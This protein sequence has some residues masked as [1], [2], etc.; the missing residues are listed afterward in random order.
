MLRVI[1]FTVVTLVVLTLGLHWAFLQTVAWTGML[2]RYSQNNS[3]QQAIQM[4]FDGEHPCTLC[5]A[6]KDG[7]DSEREQEQ[8]QTKPL[9]IDF[10]VV[11]E[12]ISLPAAPV[13]PH[14]IPQTPFAPEQAFTP[15][16]PRPRPI[17]SLVA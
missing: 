14:V 4:T 7:R 17:V 9:K 2:V 13:F 15:P 12:A 1:R 16:K 11:C 3:F 5:H 6:I 8:Q 10:A